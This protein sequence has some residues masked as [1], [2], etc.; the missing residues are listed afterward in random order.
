VSAAVSL[1]W[2]RQ[3]FRLSD[4]PALTA[5]AAAGPVVAC[6]ILDKTLPWPVA[7]AGRWWLHQSLRDLADQLARFGV[8]LIL[9]RGAAA[10]VIPALAA[11][12]GARAVHWNRLYE[13]AAI[14]RDKAL[15]TALR[16]D[17][18]EAVSHNAA[19]LFE[20]WTISTGTGG[21]YKVFT[22]FAK[23]CRSAPPPPLALPIPASI[24]GA[25]VALFSD[26]LDDW[27]LVPR[28]P[29]WAAGFGA[30]WTVGEGAA[31]AR[32]DKFLKTGL[33]AYGSQRDRPDQDGVSRLSPFLHWGQIG[34]RQIWHRVQALKA[35]DPTLAEGADKFLSE[36]LWREFAHHL[37][38]H[39][40]HIP[41]RPFQAR[42]TD[43]PWQS[44]AAALQR[45]QRGQ[46]GIPIID[47]GMRQLWQTG[48]MHNRVRMIAASFLVK[49]LL[50]PWQDG[51]AWFWDTLLDADLA[52]NAAGWQWVAG[53]GADAAPYFRVFNPVTQGEK[54]DPNGD[55]VKAFVPELSA[56]PPRLIHRPWDA[57]K[58]LAYPAPLVDLAK[59]RARALAVYKDA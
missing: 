19:L 48:W 59:G 18:R 3:D 6:Y 55:Y 17:G 54:F 56:L 50:I 21:P 16:A 8:R 58:T 24:R 38:F 22:P 11:E 51:Q 29:N 47:A 40:P 57:K 2:L 33:Q 45:W 27:G 52:N 12:L 31:A 36:I 37:L 9:R 30:V 5:A 49:H 26:N 10:T 41:E 42:F 1:V 28:H 43:F 35:T 34:P 25:D 13:P 23:T 39:F 32:L 53:C 14:A 7:G 20:P 4:N 15:K 46:T 44:D